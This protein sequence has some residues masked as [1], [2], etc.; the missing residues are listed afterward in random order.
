MI[1]KWQGL[2]AQREL[3]EWRSQVSQV[4]SDWRISGP[5]GISRAVGKGKQEGWLAPRRNVRITPPREI[6]S[7]YSQEHTPTQWVSKTQR[8]LNPSLFFF[9]LYVCIDRNRV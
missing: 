2:G 1:G 4:T 5:A 9:F 7:P 6:A 3:G 8:A